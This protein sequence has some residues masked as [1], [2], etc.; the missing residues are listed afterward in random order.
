MKKIKEWIRANHFG[1]IKDLAKNS[2]MSLRTMHR[3]LHEDIAV[4]DDEGNVYKKIG[5]L[6]PYRVRV[7]KVEENKH[8]PS[9]EFLHKKN[10]LRTRLCDMHWLPGLR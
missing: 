5:K 10:K 7:E 6:Y 2:E 9:S 1:N 8:K 3:W 4:V